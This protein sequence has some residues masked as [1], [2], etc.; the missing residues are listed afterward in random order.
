[1]VLARGDMFPDALAGVPLAAKVHGP[2]LLT[3]PG[4]A[5]HVEP[6]RDQPG[7]RRQRQIDVLGGTSAVSTAVENRLR[8]WVTR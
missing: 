7:P 5:D 2:L 6:E 8:A 3:D 4:D 1:M